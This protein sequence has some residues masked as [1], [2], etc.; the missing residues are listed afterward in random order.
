MDIGSADSGNI[1]SDDRFTGG[2]FFRQRIFAKD[3]G[4]PEGL[5]DSGFCK[6]RQTT[7]S[8]IDSRSVLR[9][10]IALQ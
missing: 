9:A 1:D 2:K 10:V 6:C 3:K 4:L 7:M 8:S 5:H